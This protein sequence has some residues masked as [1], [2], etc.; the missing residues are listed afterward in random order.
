MMLRTLLF[1]TL[2]YVSLTIGAQQHQLFSPKC[3]TLRTEMKGRQTAFPIIALNSDE[4]FVVS[5][6]EM[7]H[8]LRRYVYRVEHCDHCWQPT[9]GLFENE[10]VDALQMFTPFSKGVP[11]RNTT[12]PYTHYSLCF[13]NRE[14]R[15]LLSGNYRLYIYDEEDTETAVAIVCFAVVEPLVNIQ[16][17]VDTNTDFDWNEAHQQVAMSIDAT[18]LRAQDL[19]KELH[20]VVLQNACWENAVWDAPTTQI[21]GQRLSWKHQQ[22]LIFP[23]GNE[24]R[25]FEMLSTQQAG[26]HIDRL[27][28]IAPLYH[29]S[30]RIDEPQRNYLHIQDQNGV[31]VIRTTDN[32][33]S[34]TEADYVMTHFSLQMPQ[35]ADLDVYIDGQWANSANNKTYRMTYDTEK[36]QYR[37]ALFLKQGYYSYRYLTVSPNSIT[38]STA[39]VEGNYYQSSNDYSVLVYHQ[40]PVLRYVRLVG[41]HI[42]RSR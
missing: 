27:Q 40:S 35:L 36:G 11:S 29:A 6:D 21:A 23:A 38:R 18:S 2:I 5:F 28:W 31:A 22:Q 25:R 9:E 30:L 13:P 14:V 19:R 3:N 12:Q 7:S 41:Q 32:P 26:T 8:T 4:T 16:A 39:A 33:L 10:M 17:Q 24:Y 37:A 15:P 42:V 20:T 1:S 34:S